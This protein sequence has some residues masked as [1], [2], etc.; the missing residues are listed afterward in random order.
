[1]TYG[2][3]QAVHRDQLRAQRSMSSMGSFYLYLFRSD[4]S[5][6]FTT[7]R[8]R[9][10]Y[11]VINV[12]IL[13]QKMRWNVHKTP[14]NGKISKAISFRLMANR[15]DNA[16]RWYSF[17]ISCHH[18]YGRESVTMLSKGSKNIATSLWDS[19]AYGFQ[20]PLPAP[21]GLS[22]CYK[23]RPIAFPGRTYYKATKSGFSYYGRSA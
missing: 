3:L 2:H 14:S 18:N 4:G 7:T 20:C 19:P 11:S 13:G 15:G 23:N 17:I 5:A 22:L 10:N 12:A 16:A 9:L 8:S 1:M 6:G 21:K